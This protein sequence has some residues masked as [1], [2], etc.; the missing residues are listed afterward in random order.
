MVIYGGIATAIKRLPWS[1]V[2]LG[3]VY[4][5]ADA[6]K[7]YAGKTSASDMKFALSVLADVHF[8]AVVSYAVGASSVLYGLKQRSL[9]RATVARLQERIIGLEKLVDPNRS[10]SELPPLGT[11]REEDKP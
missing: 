6:L 5:I 4:F 8:S 9:R 11:T 3:C 1:L 10:T 2:T 7:A